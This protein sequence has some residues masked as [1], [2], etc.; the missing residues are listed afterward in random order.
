MRH[1][2]DVLH[3]L[4]DGE[5]ATIA[6][7]VA[8]TKLVGCNDGVAA[9]IHRQERLCKNPRIAS[10][11]MIDDQHR[12]GGIGLLVHVHVDVHA[13]GGNTQLLPQCFAAGDDVCIEVVFPVVQVHWLT[14]LCSRLNVI[15]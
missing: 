11:S 12:R 8:L 6:F 9:L 4:T 1:I 15:S 7:G 13:S 2:H 5:I 14:F 3:K 10:A